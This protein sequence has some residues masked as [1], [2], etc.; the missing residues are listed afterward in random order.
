VGLFLSLARVVLAACGS[1]GTTS[2]TI[3][4]LGAPDAI[5]GYA[6]SVSVLPG[7]SFRLS[8]RKAWTRKSGDAVE[9]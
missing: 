9:T 2:W 4:E 7:Q 3:S 1:S 5:E 8:M 6:S